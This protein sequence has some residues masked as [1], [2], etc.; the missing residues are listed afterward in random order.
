MEQSVRF[1]VGRRLKQARNER[2]LTMAGLAEVLGVTEKSV[3]NYESGRREPDWDTLEHIAQATGRDLAW[4]FQNEPTAQAPPPPRRPR[5]LPAANACAI[6]HGGCGCRPGRHRRPARG[7]RMMQAMGAGIDYLEVL[8]GPRLDSSMG[9]RRMRSRSRLTAAP[10]PS[11][12]LA[13]RG[14]TR[15]RPARAARPQERGA[16]GSG[17]PRSPP[18]LDSCTP[19]THS[20]ACGYQRI[21]P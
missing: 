9:S 8:D 19:G 2:G 14:G 12:S 4:F 7:R 10:G 6:H 20:P 11:P 1:R 3:T 17:R 13:G 15:L 18:S 16:G 21:A 5:V